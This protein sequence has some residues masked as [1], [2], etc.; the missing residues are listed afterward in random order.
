MS[1]KFLFFIF[2]LAI[3]GCDKKLQSAIEASQKGVALIASSEV[4]EG[5]DS[6]FSAKSI[7]EELLVENPENALYQN[8][9][10]WVLMQLKEYDAAEIQFNK[11]AEKSESINPS[12]APNENLAELAILKAQ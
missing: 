1:S 4:E 2:V 10:G 3:A 11:A 5:R 7:Y 8:N 12:S 6:L 9:Y